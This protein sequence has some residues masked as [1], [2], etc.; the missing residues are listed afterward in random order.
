[1]NGVNISARVQPVLDPGFVPAVLWNRAYEALAAKDARGRTLSRRLNLATA[2]AFG[3]EIVYLRGTEPAA[4][5]GELLTAYLTAGIEAWLWRWQ[6]AAGTHTQLLARR[7]I[8]SR[9][10]FF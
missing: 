1:M 2:L 4:L 8:F 6:V 10:G 7:E 5:F 9:G 3:R